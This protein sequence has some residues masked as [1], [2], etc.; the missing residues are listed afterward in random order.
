MQAS[1]FP[2]SVLRAPSPD[3]ECTCTHWLHCNCVCHDVHCD[4]GEA[5][6]DVAY[7]SDD[8]GLAALGCADCTPGQ[9]SPH[10][11]GCELI[12]WHVPMRDVLKPV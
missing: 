10:L 1:P 6:C 12:G 4:P 8:G 7:L 2:A 9:R 11:L 3:A 5:A